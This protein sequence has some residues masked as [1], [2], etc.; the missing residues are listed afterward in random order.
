MKERSSESNNSEKLDIDPTHNF[1]RRRL[2]SLN[3]WL[4]KFDANK[5]ECCSVIFGISGV[6]LIIL[7]VCIF[8][9]IH[10]AYEH[11][12]INEINC[13]IVNVTHTHVKLCESYRCQIF[14]YCIPYLCTSKVIDFVQ[15]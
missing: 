13:S 7:G 9:I 2:H 8:I 14:N 4:R 15:E 6:S 3:I 5:L 10:T 1:V 11:H 12:S